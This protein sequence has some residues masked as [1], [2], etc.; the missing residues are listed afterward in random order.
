M[1]R[2]TSTLEDVAREA[3]VSKTTAASIL[4]DQRGF[5]AS[6]D[7]RRRVVTAAQRLGYRRN[8][9][10]AALSSGR[11]HTVGILLP[12][13][14]P[15]AGSNVP[16]SFGQKVFVSLYDAASR[17]G[18][19]VLPA[20][21][22]LDGPNGG[23]GGPELQDLADGRV[24]GLI[25][26]SL[27]NPE[28]VEQ[29]YASGLPCVEMSSGFGRRLIHP[30]NEGGAALAVAHLAGLGHRRIAH[31]RGGSAGNH[32]G[33]HR[34]SGFLA[35]AGRH[36]LRSEET[37]VLDSSEAVIDVLRRPAG[38]RPTA[39]FAFNDYQAFMALDI[40]RG[41]GLRVPED[42]SIVG[43]DDTIVAELARPALTTVHNPLDEQARAAIDLL[44]ALWRGEADP[45]VP[46]PLSTRLVVR[47][48]TT[49]A[50][51]DL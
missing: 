42:L 13:L 26:V 21:P 40:A 33:D 11:T 8:A 43:F 28:F 9:L 48:S 6:A 45:P 16:N 34:L 2:M 27:R 32:A 10:A 51:A 22:P 38:E 30:D 39:L 36:G 3:G 24:D 12:P 17:C 15:G 19:R 46:P 25:M 41:A 49:A 18:L 20:A 7:T 37:P 23:G 50:P 1:K 35:A 5:Q 31:W 47:N 4:R 44:Q 14:H 29:V